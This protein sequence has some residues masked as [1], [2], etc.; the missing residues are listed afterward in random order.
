MSETKKLYIG[1]VLENKYIDRPLAEVLEE[2]YFDDEWV[3][4]IDNRNL[5]Y[6]I[7]ELVSMGDPID[8]YNGQTLDAMGQKEI[9]G[10]WCYI[11]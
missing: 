1:D 4:I 2:I 9:L 6:K 5:E 3:P 10:V 11:F 8:G 7:V